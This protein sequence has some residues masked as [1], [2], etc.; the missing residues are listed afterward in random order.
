MQDQHKRPVTAN[1]QSPAQFLIDNFSLFADLP[2]GD[3]LDLAC[4]SGRNGLY[5]ARHFKDQASHNSSNSKCHPVILADKQAELLRSIEATICTERLNAK[6]WQTDFESTDIS[7]LTD[8][9]FSAILVFRYLHRPLFQSIKDA[10]VPGGLVV[11]ETF[12][13]DQ[14]KYGRPKNPNFLLQ[15]GELKIC[16]EGWEIVAYDEGVLDKSNPSAI[17]RIICRKPLN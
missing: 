11:Y 9:A 14:P 16:F 2:D 13:I 6:T 1:T 17:A 15:P 8:K 4:G 3:I 10:V 12:T 7:P 5:L